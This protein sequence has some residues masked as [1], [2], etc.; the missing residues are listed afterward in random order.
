MPLKTLS[1]TSTLVISYFLKVF[2][3]KHIKITQHDF[4]GYCDHVVG[5]PL[6]KNRSICRGFKKSI[7]I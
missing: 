5:Y 7:Y 4:R 2:S 6:T 3:N 1:F